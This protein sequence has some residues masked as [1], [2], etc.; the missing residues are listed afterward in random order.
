MV[1]FKNLEQTY[2]IAEIGI[3]HNGDINIA[4]KLIDAS[5]AIG[6]DCVKFQK[7]D[8]DICV[9]EHQKNVLRKTP[10]GEMTYL[11]YKKKIEFASLEYDKINSYCKSKK[12]NIHWTASVWDLNSL[13]F[14]LKYKDIPFI[15]IPSAMISNQVLL[16]ACAKSEKPIIFSTGMSTLKEIDDAFNIIDKFSNNYCLLHTN[17]SYPAPIEDL[18]LSLIPFYIDRY[19]CPV[20]YSGHEYN[21]EPSVIAVTLGAKII[22]RHI[23]LDHEMWGTDHKS[24][25]TI[26]GMDRLIV[27]VRTAEQAIGKPI[28]KITKEEEIIR[29]KLGIK[30]LN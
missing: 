20:G 12:P 30:P 16:K 10:W 21:I 18:N 14:I 28:K 25:L 5:Y 27:R 15:K 17:S 26:P 9:P 6:W 4:K 13:E 2:L 29:K 1:N 22:E 19:K 24:S 3:N 23:T 7:R 11:N 8:P